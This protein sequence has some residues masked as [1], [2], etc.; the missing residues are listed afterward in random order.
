[1][2]E[3]IIIKILS[4][5][6]IFILITSCGKSPFTSE[7]LNNSKPTEIADGSL[8][9]GKRLGSYDLDF[10][11]D[12]EFILY[13]ENQAKLNITQVDGEQDFID[14]S[15]LEIYLWMPEH[16]HGSYPINVSLDQSGNIL[17]RDMYFTMPGNW[18]L[19]IKSIKL[20]TSLSWP[21]IL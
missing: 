9:K 8:A 5:F 18:I 7:L 15:D 17:L 10:R 6:L 19:I 13:N 21:I 1:M 14:I 3:D 11:H 2:V 4:L 16:G 12:G 20:N